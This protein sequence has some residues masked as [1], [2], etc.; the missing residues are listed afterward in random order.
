[1][2]FIEDEFAL[3]INFKF[4]GAID[5]MDSPDHHAILSFEGA[6]PSDNRERYNAGMEYTFQNFASFRIGQRFEHDL[7]GISLGG[8]LSFGGLPVPLK[9]DYGYRDFEVLGDI[10]RFSFTV[11]L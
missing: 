4:G 9:V 3:P 11:D 5:V 1:M 10:H 6:H 7:G 8:G 2:K